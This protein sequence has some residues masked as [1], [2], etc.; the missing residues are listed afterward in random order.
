M[1]CCSSDIGP[2]IP[3]PETDFSGLKDH[4]NFELINDLKVCGLVVTDRVIGGEI[5]QLNQFPWLVLLM[6]KSEDGETES[7]KCGGTL[8]SNRYVLTGEYFTSFIYH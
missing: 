1:V 6:Y 3:L 7:F 5:A 8:I 2:R 4:K